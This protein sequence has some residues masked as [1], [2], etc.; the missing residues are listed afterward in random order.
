MCVYVCV[1]AKDETAD[2]LIQYESNFYQTYIHLVRRRLKKTLKFLAADYTNVD[3]Y[4]SN[5]SHY[6]YYYY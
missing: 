6:Y 2:I 3:I 1:E 5:Y 4:I